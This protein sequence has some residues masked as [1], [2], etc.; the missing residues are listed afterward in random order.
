MQNRSQYDGHIV[1]MI[2]AYGD[3]YEA[4]YAAAEIAYVIEHNGKIPEWACYI[5]QVERVDGNY[6]FVHKDRSVVQ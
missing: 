5:E 1:S 6:V 2:S 4:L 3:T